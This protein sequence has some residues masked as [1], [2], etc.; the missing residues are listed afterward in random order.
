M[1][2]PNQREDAT[3]AGGG[4]SGTPALP[5]RLA[6]SLSGG[7]ARGAYQ[8]GVIRGL[9]RH[10]PDLHIPLLSGVSAGAINVVFLAA[11]P[12]PLGVAAEALA[13][14]WMSLEASKV[15]RVDASSLTRSFLR[16]VTRLASGDAALAPEVKGLVDTRPLE[17]SINRSVPV[18]DGEIVGIGRSL[19]RG[20]LDAVAVT[21]LNY[22]TGQT[23]TWIQGRQFI[24][25]NEPRRRSVAARLTV[26]HVMASAA[27]PLFFP[28]VRL[29]DDY[30]GDG[31]IRLSAPLAPSLYMGAT[32]I[33][34][35]SPRYEPSAQEA[36]G[37]KTEGYPPP[38]Q[39]LSQVMSAVFLD[40]LDRDARQVENLNRLLPLVPGRFHE[41]LRLVDLLVL[42][43]S[44]D[45]GRLAG[46]YEAKLPKAFRH[47]TRSLGTRKTQSP[48]FLSF[49]LFQPDYMKRLLDI[50]EADVEARIGE[51]R[52]L[53]E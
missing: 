49:L 32:K 38:A 5:P 10:F 52:A 36:A 23:I 8:A 13:S 3:E 4:A 40:A 7:G 31:G 33:L 34:A 2:E 27:L 21:T 18:V 9:G 51:I 24:P 19:D 43:P 45:L 17:A 28:A 29:G 50:G 1:T 12:G 41:D 20:T 53:V 44:Q 35:V 46:D 11:H 16:W 30:H 37:R 39:I 42:R 48:D 15:F 26:S 25:W 22:T 47:L 6:L 14:L